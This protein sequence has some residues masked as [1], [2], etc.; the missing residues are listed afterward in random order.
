[1][2]QGLRTESPG[3][4]AELLLAF[5]DK[6]VEMI[7]HAM[8]LKSVQDG[9]V[10]MTGAGGGCKGFQ[11]SC[12]A[13]CSFLIGEEVIGDPQR[14]V[15][16]VSVIGPAVMKH[17]FGQPFVSKVFNEVGEEGTVC[18]APTAAYP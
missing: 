5:T 15:L 17:G 1:M 14:G 13:R 12:G 16:N 3:R 4:T 2:D 9:G 11:Y 8:R 18:R 7:K 10:R 6:A